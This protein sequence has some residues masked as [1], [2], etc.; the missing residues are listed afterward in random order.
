MIKI[1]GPVTQRIIDDDNKW[2]QGRNLEKMAYTFKVKLMV[3]IE[4]NGLCLEH[5]KVMNGIF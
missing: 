5:Y 3:S 2:D 4:N 1:S